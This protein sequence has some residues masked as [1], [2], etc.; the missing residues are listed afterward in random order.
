MVAEGWEEYEEGDE[1]QDDRG[2]TT[3]GTRTKT[4]RRT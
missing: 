4:K 3:M 1:K 2:T